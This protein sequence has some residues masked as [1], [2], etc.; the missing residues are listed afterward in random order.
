[1]IFTLR[2]L[3]MTLYIAWVFGHE[4]HIRIPV[5]IYDCAK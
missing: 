5:A 2:S 3:W 4:V 1:M